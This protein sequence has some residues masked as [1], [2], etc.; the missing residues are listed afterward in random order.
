MLSLTQ[1][2]LDPATA[3]ALEGILLKVMAPG[4]PS[5]AFVEAEARVAA[6]VL[7][8]LRSERTKED[9]SS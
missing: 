7:D 1:I 5:P 2:S 8:Q 3:S 6:D 4:S 9:Q